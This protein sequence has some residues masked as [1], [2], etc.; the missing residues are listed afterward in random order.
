MTNWL[1]IQPR[2][3][4]LHLPWTPAPASTTAY[5]I[6]FLI[7]YRIPTV[8]GAGRNVYGIPGEPDLMHLRREVTEGARAIERAFGVVPRWYRGATAEYDPQAI[9]EIGKLGYKIAGFSVNADAGATLNRRSI[10]ERLKHVK[11]GDII[12]AHMNKPAGDSAEDLSAALADMLQAGFKVVRLGQ[13]N[14]QEIRDPEEHG[15]KK[16]EPRHQGPAIGLP[17]GR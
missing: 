11:N 8:I 10:E 7:L 4:E 17:N 3:E 14:E 16:I 2:P 9:E 13:L 1:P 12:N 15:G 5:L 6:D